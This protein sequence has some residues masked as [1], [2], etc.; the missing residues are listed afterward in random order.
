MTAK[1]KAIFVPIWNTAVSKEGRDL[2]TSIWGLAIEVACIAMIVVSFFDSFTGRYD[3]ATF[4]LA[5]VILVRV[6][7]REQ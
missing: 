1:L 7:R 3:L 4:E 2:A 5:L 6:M